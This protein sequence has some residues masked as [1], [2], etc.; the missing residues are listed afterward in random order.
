[1]GLAQAIS[2]LRIRGGTAILGR[3]KRQI[4]D[5]DSP[6][7]ASNGVPRAIMDIQVWSD[8]VCPWC[9]IGKRRLEK[10][11]A[12]F[13]R[14]GDRDV[15]GRTSSTRRRCRSRCRSR[16]RWPRKFGGTERAE[17]MFAHVTA[18]AAGDGLH[19]RLRPGDR[20][21]HVR[22]PPAGRLGGRPG[23]PGRDGGRAPAGALR[24]TA[25]TSAPG[26]RWPTVAG[27]IGLDRGRGAG[28]PRVRRP[29]PARSTPTWPRPANS[30]SPAS[31]PS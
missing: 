4:R 2:P 19:A 15:P 31:R 1:M 3:L 9:Y 16:R 29:A 20:G 28:L 5:A 6:L 23:P 25:S 17:Q 14:R 22:R 30:A 10:A 13:R 26:R 12:E 7:T 21:Q 24:R 8:V 11:L 27:G 18:V